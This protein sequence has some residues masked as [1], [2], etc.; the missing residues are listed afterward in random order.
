MNTRLVWLCPVILC[1]TCKSKDDGD[2]R[3]L[4]VPPPE[5]ATAAAPPATAAAPAAAATTPPPAASA[6]AAA[7]AGSEADAAP[8]SK[9]TNE[10]TNA[11]TPDVANELGRLNVSTSTEGLRQ[12]GDVKHQLLK[13]AGRLADSPRTLSAV[14]NHDLVVESFMERPDIVKACRERDALRPILVWA[15]KHP[16]AEAIVKNKESANVVADSKLTKAFVKCPAFKQLTSP[17]S[18]FLTRAAQE[19]PAIDRVVHHEN[20]RAALERLGIKARIP[21]QGPSRTGTQ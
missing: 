8:A 13:I 5:T 20:F 21:R 11:I 1:L 15:L 4:P 10:A 18:P 19:E 9:N 12:L 2:T 7:D 16:T 3:P 6:S 17:R 14:M